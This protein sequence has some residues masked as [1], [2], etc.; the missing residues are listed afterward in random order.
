MTF[1]FTLSMQGTFGISYIDVALVGDVEILAEFQLNGTFG[2]NVQ[3][4]GHGRTRLSRICLLSDRSR[5]GGGDVV[6]DVVEL[7]VEIIDF[8]IQTVN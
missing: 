1:V 8:R 4:F 2:G 7:A 6:P 3:H 5:L